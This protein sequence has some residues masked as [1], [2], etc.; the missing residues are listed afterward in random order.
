MGLAVFTIIGAMAELESLLIAEAQAGKAQAG[1]RWLA[2]CELG[3][4]GEGRPVR[5]A[6]LLRAQGVALRPGRREPGSV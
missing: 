6:E 2:C 5:E 1:R 3:R 4:V